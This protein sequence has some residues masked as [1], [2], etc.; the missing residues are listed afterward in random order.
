VGGEGTQRNVLK[1]R[2]NWGNVERFERIKEQQGRRKQESEAGRK[3]K[4]CAGA[5]VCV[6][7]SGNN[8]QWRALGSWDVD[9][10]AKE[11]PGN[12]KKLTR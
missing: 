7:M 1:Q 6:Y 12:R 3:E 8:C 2:E 9:S 5:C 11:I 4:D 10:A